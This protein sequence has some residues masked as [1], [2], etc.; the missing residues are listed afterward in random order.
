MG[1]F[2][3][4]LSCSKPPQ[5][6]HAAALD[7]W[8]IDLEVNNGAFGASSD[9]LKPGCPKSLYIGAAGETLVSKTN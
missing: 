6:K 3:W 7:E 5:G 8:G 4:A 9:F 1:L 2:C